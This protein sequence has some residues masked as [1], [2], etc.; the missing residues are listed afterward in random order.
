MTSAAQVSC[1]R[2]CALIPSRNDKK[3]AQSGSCSALLSIGQLTRK[4]RKPG[5]QDS[6]DD[7]T[8]TWSTNT[9]SFFGEWRTLNEPLRLP[10]SPLVLGRLHAKRP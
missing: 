8:E 5:I 1:N 3:D 7:V 2:Y 10:D 6:N 4:S 9:G